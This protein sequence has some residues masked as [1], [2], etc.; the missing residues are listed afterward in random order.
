M[1][2]FGAHLL[3]HTPGQ[4]VTRIDVGE[5]EM[6]KGADTEERTDGVMWARAGDALTP[7][8]ESRSE[9]CVH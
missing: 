3:V 7:S 4:P 5:T 6:W 8:E 2:L 9:L 1:T